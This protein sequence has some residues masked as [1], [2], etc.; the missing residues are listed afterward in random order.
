MALSTQATLDAATQELN[1]PLRTILR[2]NHAIALELEATV[3]VTGDGLAN[4]ETRVVALE[5]FFAGA[6]TDTPTVAEMTT[7]PPIF[8]GGLFKGLTP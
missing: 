4:L 8:A 5:T 3:G 7:N 6:D 2:T 1:E